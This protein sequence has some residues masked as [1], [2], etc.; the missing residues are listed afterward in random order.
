MRIASISAPI[1]RFDRCGLAIVAVAMMVL[2]SLAPAQ[3]PAAALS[4]QDQAYRTRMGAADRK[5]EAEVKAHSELVKNLEYLSDRIGPRPV[6]SPQMRKASAWTL[7]RFHD[8]GI[9]AHLETTPVSHAWYRGADTA[10]IVS[11]IQRQVPIHSYAWGKATGGDISGPV[12][13]LDDAT[14]EGVKQ[15]HEK[16]KGAFVLLTKDTPVLPAGQPADSAFDSL[17]PPGALGP[18]PP[19]SRPPQTYAD[20]WILNDAI[21]AAGAIGILTDSA[22]PDRLFNMSS[23]T[24]CCD[25]SPLPMAFITHEDYSLI[26]RLSQ[27]EP[28]T[29]KINLKGTFSPGPQPASITVAEIK[30][31][32]HPEERVIIGGHLDSWDLGDGALDNGAG[33]MATLEAA[34]AL[35]A[36]GWQPKRTLTFILFTGEELG[37]VGSKLFVKNHAAELAKIDG[38]LVLD[39]GTGRVLDISLSNLWETSPMM[40]MINWP[41]RDAFGLKPLEARFYA[42]SDHVTFV[43]AGV[44]G[45]LCVQAPAQYREA[46]HSQ[47]DTFD[48][49]VPEEINQ[50]AAV[51]ASWIWNTSEYP[52]AMPHHP[53]IAPQNYLGTSAP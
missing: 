25:A 3:N 46:H 40:N 12:V 47:A 15:Q 53:P 8:Y 21:A 38:V 27:S 44:P 13:F 52:E 31:S 42:G 30:G 6:G 28:V 9:D 11:P 49:V 26:Y 10:E 7:E 24:Q 1:L 2:P 14:V 16:L 5:I 39:T 32:E 22:K 45:F 37:G 18:Q 4:D 41:L 43:R 33:A 20:R 34:R 48:K 19:S 51:I 23:A 29:V 50:A 17:L 36:L 35:K